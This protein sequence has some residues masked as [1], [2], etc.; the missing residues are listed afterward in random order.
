[1]EKKRTISQAE[2]ALRRLEELNNFAFRMCEWGRENGMHNRIPW[3]ERLNYLP[4]DAVPL[5]P[6]GT[7]EPEKMVADGAEVAEERKKKQ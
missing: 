1:M 2:R 5:Y 7:A 4:P 3:K 6:E